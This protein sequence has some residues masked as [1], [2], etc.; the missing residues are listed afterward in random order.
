M[1]SKYVLK[2]WAVV[3]SGNPYHAPEQLKAKLSGQV[4]N[5]PHFPDGTEIVT[6]SIKKADKREITTSSGNLYYIF[7]SP[8]DDYLAFLRDNNLDYNPIE[9]IKLKQKPVEIPKNKFKTWLN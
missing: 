2:N 1:K 9:P 5:H 6:S 7:E 8:S 3:Y 4:Y